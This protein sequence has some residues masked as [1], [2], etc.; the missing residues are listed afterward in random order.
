MNTVLKAG[1]PPLRGRSA[2][3]SALRE[4]LRSPR[5][6]GSL[7]MSFEGAPGMGKSRLLAEA[8]AVAEASGAEVVRGLH[9]SHGVFDRP[10]VVLLDDT[11]RSDTADARALAALR[12]STANVPVVWCT[13]RRCGSPSSPLESALESAAVSRR[14][15]RLGALDDRAAQE[16][17]GD[18][19]GAR[20]DAA[21]ARAAASLSGHPRALRAFVEGLLEEGR[22]EV[23]AAACLT[24]PGIPERL[25][26]LVR[27]Y[28]QDCSRPCATM[29]LVASTLGMHLI[30][31]ELAEILGAK[32]SCLLPDLQEAVFSGLLSQDGDDVRFA[33]EPFRDIIRGMVPAAAR[34]AIR[35]QADHYR[36]R[37]FEEA[38]AGFPGSP[39]FPGN[40]APGPAAVLLRTPPTHRTAGGVV[41]S[42]PCRGPEPAG[43]PADRRAPAVASVFAP[44]AA[45]TAPGV[46]AGPRCAESAGSGAAA[47]PGWE[48]LT[49]KQVAAA[50]LAV[51][52]MTNKE[53]AARLHLSPHTVN[54]HL[55]K[56]FR[57]LSIRS[58]TEL[59]R[60][61]HAASPAAGLR[62]AR[63]GLFPGGAA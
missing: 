62:P 48:R 38:F 21:L 40:A 49:E 60:L 29:L 33:N 16:M 4:A 3:V 11:H 2:E 6:P 9:G 61:V 22:V 15:F 63:E 12:P 13:G 31:G 26:D 56:I 42:G 52:G 53:I 45:D 32:P 8:G 36:A 24:R 28:V 7:H 10:L 14:S 20:P 34:A 46:P 51:E 27:R 58:R 57:A 30:F 37:Q 23:G 19:L 55:R 1:T 59:I 50:E 5:R 47:I 39:G 18:L 43:V 17:V 54:Y 25:G 35:E 44:R 41:L